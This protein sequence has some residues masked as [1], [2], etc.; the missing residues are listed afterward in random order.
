MQFCNY[1]FTI[2]SLRVILI[3]GENR[4]YSLIH[5]KGHPV[6]KAKSEAEIAT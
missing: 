6:L 2:N 1:C 3:I 5:S 4:R